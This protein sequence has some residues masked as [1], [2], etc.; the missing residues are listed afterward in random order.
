MPVTAK[1]LNW[2][3]FSR[4]ALE[5][6]LFAMRLLFKR[7]WNAR[8]DVKYTWQDDESSGRIFMEGTPWSDWTVV[9][10]LPGTVSVRNG[11]TD[12]CTTDDLHAVS[13]RKDS[14]VRFGGHAARLKADPQPPKVVSTKT[15]TKDVDGKILFDPAYTGPDADG[16][17]AELVT[18]HRDIDKAERTDS[19][20]IDAH[21]ERK[22]RSGYT[23]NWDVTVL[24]TALCGL[25]N[26]LVAIVHNLTSAN[27]GYS[28]H[29]MHVHRGA[30]CGLG[31]FL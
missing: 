6:L 26:S 18:R 4:I 29:G 14:Y 3:R 23:A 19:K 11:R 20:P 8:Y 13:A 31:D 30:F 22:L 7:L 21:I 17:V 16:L 5:V 10:I 28:P 1:Q 24:R 27:A 9:Q 15:G 2:Y 12:A 25:K